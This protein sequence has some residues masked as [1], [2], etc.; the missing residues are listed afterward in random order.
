MH[1]R[2][3]ST[4]R[5]GTVHTLKPSSPAPAASPVVP[6]EKLWPRNEPAM[7]STPGIPFA[8]DIHPGEYLII[9][10]DQRDAGGEVIGADR[11]RKTAIR[12]AE[13][14]DMDDNRFV[15]VAR[16]DRVLL[17]GFGGRRT[18]LHAPAEIAEAADEPAPPSLMQ[19]REQFA[20]FCAGFATAA[21]LAMVTLILGMIGH[22]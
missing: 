11:D 1:Q 21:T 17:A 7:E 10:L 16:V 20:T 9:A 5:T 13:R 2:A 15:A 8:E 4:R 14:L 12:R 6:V 3:F 22:G 19:G 18:H